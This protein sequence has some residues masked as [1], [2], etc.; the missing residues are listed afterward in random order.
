V[1][2]CQRLSIREQRGFEVPAGKNPT[3]A[4]ARPVPPAFN[5]IFASL[6]QTVPGGPGARERREF[7]DVQRTVRRCGGARRAIQSDRAQTGRNDEAGASFAAGRSAEG[8]S[9]VEIC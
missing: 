4:A 2:R 1:L 6:A 7:A 3:V 8:G 9:G 5:E